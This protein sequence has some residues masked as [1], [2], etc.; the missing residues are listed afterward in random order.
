[1]YDYTCTSIL[2][3]GKYEALIKAEIVRVKS[4]STTDRI[5]QK[6]AGSTERPEGTLWKED[7]LDKLKGVGKC[8][9]DKLKTAGIM[10][11][12]DLCELDDDALRKVQESSRISVK[13]LKTYQDQARKAT[14]GKSPFP[15]NFDWVAGNANPYEKRYGSNWRNVIKK[16][17]RSGLTRF[18]C[19]T[20]LVEHIDRETAKCFAGTPYAK[21]YYWSHDALKQMCDKRCTAW[22]KEKGYY[23]RWIKPELE[24]NDVVTI[25]TDSGEIKHNH[26]YK[27]RPVGDQPEL[28]PLDASL[29]WDI[30]CSLNMHVMMTWHLKQEDPLKFSKATPKEISKGILKIYD[31]KNGVAPTS[32]RIIQDVKR[33]LTSLETIV[34]AGGKVVEGLVNR[35]GHRRRK[36]KGRKYYPKKAT[37]E[38]M[39]LKEMGIFEDVQKVAVEHV[40]QDAA[41]YYK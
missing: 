24:C 1:M 22:M 13:F 40:K 35:N 33:V 29:N 17:S 27:N 18:R 11:L 5:S 28:M 39:T 6:W 26:H 19:V 4:L 30:D 2:T 8:K 38:I 21:N 25:T 41:N 31:P 37:P 23:D 15:K 10:K 9:C 36:S 16:V 32:K 12:Q 34:E 14:D 3:I 7:P 20:E